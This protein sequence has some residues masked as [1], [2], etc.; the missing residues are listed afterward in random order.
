MTVAI[1]DIPSGVT[2][3]AE[4]Q[5]HKNV[6]ESMHHAYQIPDNR[7]YLREWTAKQTSFDGVVG[8]AFRPDLPLD[9]SANPHRRRQAGAHI[10]R[11]RRHRSS[12]RSGH[13]S[14]I[15][16]ERQA[17]QHAMG[18]VVLF[19]GSGEQAALDELMAFE[20]RWCLRTSTDGGKLCEK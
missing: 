3:K 10:A 1:I 15:A 13:R 12:L 7:V 20:I 5:L 18:A 9:L 2:T 16:P 4:N 11:E 17:N 14:R 8:A 19:R 6:A